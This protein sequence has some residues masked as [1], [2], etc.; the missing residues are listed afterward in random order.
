MSAK[1]LGS[2]VSFLSGTEFAHN[3]GIAVRGRGA[4]LAIV[5]GAVAPKDAVDLHHGQL[6]LLTHFSD[7]GHSLGGAGL[8][9]LGFPHTVSAKK[10][11]NMDV[12]LDPI[13]AHVAQVFP[14]K[15]LADAVQLDSLFPKSG[16]SL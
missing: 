7:N 6:Q 8:L 9:L 16:A 15:R 11:A 14:G 4:D 10:P 1:K 12:G 3:T 5:A 2:F 13:D